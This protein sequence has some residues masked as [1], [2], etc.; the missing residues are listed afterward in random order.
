MGWEGMNY[1]VVTDNYFTSP[2]LYEDLLRR[3]FYAV[4][5][6][7]QGRVGFPTSLHLPEKGTCGSLQIRMH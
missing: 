7:R 1:T 6:A 5:I 3:G 4:G 2:M